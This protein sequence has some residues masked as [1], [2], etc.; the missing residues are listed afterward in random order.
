MFP[1]NKDVFC[2]N[3]VHITNAAINQR[4]RRSVS[5]R[6]DEFYGRAVNLSCCEMLL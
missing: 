2:E 1:I 6:C 5:F 3:L 4:D